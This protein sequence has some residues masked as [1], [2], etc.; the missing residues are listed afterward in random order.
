[1]QTITQLICFEQTKEGDFGERID[2]SCSVSLE[3]WDNAR[4]IMGNVDKE[5]TE[6]YELSYIFLG[7]YFIFLALICFSIFGE[8]YIIIDEKSV[9]MSP[10]LV[11][12]TSADFCFIIVFFFIRIWYS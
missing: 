10:L 6:V 12:H 7:I 8:F 3:T 5:E 11:I 1:M 9:Y 2:I 4:R